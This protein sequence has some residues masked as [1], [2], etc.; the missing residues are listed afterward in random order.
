M[1]KMS[2]VISSLMPFPNIFWWCKMIDALPVKWE[3]HE[4]FQKSTYHNRYYIAGANGVLQMSVPIDG[5]R[6]HKFPMK[7]VRISYQEDWQKRHWRTLVSAYNRAPYFEFYADGLRKV[8][9]EKYDRLADFNLATIHWLKQQLT[10]FFQEENTAFYEK[11]FPKDVTDLRDMKQRIENGANCD[12]PVY[13]QVFQERTGFHPNLS[14]LD[15]LFAEGKY[16]GEWL[17][18][19]KNIVCA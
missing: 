19:N 5:G 1:D 9:A 10:V 4:H 14:M 2:F 8:F 6:E 13:Y 12:F 11:K 18:L 15:L 16:A 17:R 7:D 3:L